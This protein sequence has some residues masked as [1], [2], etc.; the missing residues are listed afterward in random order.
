[1][2]YSVVKSQRLIRISLKSRKRFSC[3]SPSNKLNHFLNNLLGKEISVKTTLKD[4]LTLLSKL[5]CSK[6]TESESRN[7]LKAFEIETDFMT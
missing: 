5:L 2:F 6:Q 4:E 1:M 7:F 3:V